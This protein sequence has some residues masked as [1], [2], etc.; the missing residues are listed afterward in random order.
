MA[1]SS[2]KM[3]PQ[4]KIIQERANQSRKLFNSNGFYL[5]LRDFG[6]RSRRIQNMIYC[7]N[8]NQEIK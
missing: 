3:N 4:E 8:I 6:T 7:K 5:S 2:N 1:D